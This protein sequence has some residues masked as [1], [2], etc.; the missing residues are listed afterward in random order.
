MAAQDIAPKELFNI[1]GEKT[2]LI[3]C[4]LEII[5]SYIPN[6][7]NELLKQTENMCND[8]AHEIIK[9]KILS[10]V[11]KNRLI[12]YDDDEVISYRTQLR[13]TLLLLNSKLTYQSCRRSKFH[14]FIL[15]LIVF[16]KNEEHQEENEYIKGCCCKKCGKYR[17]DYGYNDNDVVYYQR[18]CIYNSRCI[19]VH[20][21]N[22]I[23]DN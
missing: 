4:L 6:K 14:I 11:V 10:M 20:H 15:E 16:V 1:L 22:C 2:K 19:D 23:L 18:M 9:K 8:W 21:L 17:L 13:D 3:S 5:M 7:L 12:Y